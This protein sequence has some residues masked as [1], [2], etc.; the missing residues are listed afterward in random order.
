MRTATR[1]FGCVGITMIVCAGCQK[2]SVEKT[3]TMDVGDMKGAAL[4]DGPKSEQKIKV[5]FTSSECPV[6]VFVVVGKDSNKI[7]D[8]LFKAAPKADIRAKSEKAKEGTLDATIP[9]N[10]DYGVYLSGASKKTEVK[11]KIKSQ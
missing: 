11:V 8:E 7:L 6:N 9:A 3:V 5:E 2:I 10:E 4:I 1:L